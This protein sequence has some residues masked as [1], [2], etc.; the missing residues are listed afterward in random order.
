MSRK[1]RKIARTRLDLSPD[2]EA[3]EEWETTAGGT[4]RAVGVGAGVTGHGAQLMMIDDP[5]QNREEADSLVYRDRVWDWYTNDL[6]TRLE[7]NGAIVAI[8]ARWHEDDLAG[9]ILASSD[10]PNWEVI[11][12]PAEAEE[13]D[14]LGRPIG[15]PLWP[16]RF[17]A[18]ELA[19]RKLVLG[20]D[21][22]A[23][24]QQRPQPRE[25]E[26]FKRA[27][28]EIVDA[29][30]ADAQRVRYQDKAGTSGGGAFTSEVLIAA[31]KGIY[32][33][34][35]VQRGQWGAA[36]REAHFRQSAELDR[37]AGKS[38]RYW[39]E[40]EPGS[41]GKES[42]EATIRNMAG[43]MIRADKVTG[44]KELRAE[45]MAAQAMAGNVKI[46]RG[47]WNAAFLDE[48]TSFPSGML[49]DQVDA[50]SGAFN[51]LSARGTLEIY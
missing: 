12:L 36:E 38:V 18:D 31:S 19:D 30:P 17:T 16:E 41:G 5:V 11:R 22:Y 2:R 42:A 28:F 15:E 8:M 20:R 47:P 9:R 1:A 32:Y 43:F 27:W 39:T 4:L 46:V 49:R 33:I 21:Y 45:P 24:Y 44:S 23:L 25:G 7:P 48:I 14:P 3:V 37:Q 26:M 50:A 51:K 29:V 10:G 13:S 35:D 6:Y 40:Q 34:E